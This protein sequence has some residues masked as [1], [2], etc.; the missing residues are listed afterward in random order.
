MDENRITQ[1]SPQASGDEKPTLK[2]RLLPHYQMV[3]RWSRGSLDIVRVMV[4]NFGLARGAEAAASLAYY[5]LFSLFPLL[6]VLISVVGYIL[7]SGDAYTVTLDFITQ[8]LPN[9]RVLIELNI[10]EILNRRGTIGLIGLVGAVWAASGFFVTL[11]RNI[12][13]AWLGIKPRNIIRTR[14]LGLA[15]IGMLI[16]LLVLSLASSA[17]LNIVKLIDS[18]LLNSFQLENS[19]FWQLLRVLLPSL[20]SFLMFMAA[21]RWIPN[22]RVRWRACLGGALWTSIAW[23]IAKRLFAAYLSSGL[24]NYEIL[25]GSLGTVLALMFWI[26]VSCVIILLGAHLTASID[27]RH[28][29]AI[30]AAADD[31]P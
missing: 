6:L 19:V 22:T 26:Y 13:R 27:F 12:N 23:E 18:P 20:F 10:Q 14:L 4:K 29:R 16:L 9:S 5:A 17:L 24:G 25:Y 8:I 7:K 3:N 28:Q 21:Y 11:V 1:G 30:A 2:Q 15:M 31:N